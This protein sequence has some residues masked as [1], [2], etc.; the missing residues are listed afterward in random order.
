[1]INGVVKCINYG[2]HETIS[3]GALLPNHLFKRFCSASATWMA[4]H[5]WVSLLTLYFLHFFDVLLS[6]ST[7]RLAFNLTSIPAALQAS[8]LLPLDP[9]SHGI[10]ALSYPNKL[11]MRPNL[12]FHTQAMHAR[13]HT[14]P[15][16][17]VVL[18]TLV[19]Q[20][21]PPHLSHTFHSLPPDLLLSSF[22]R[23]RSGTT[24]E[25]VTQIGW[26]L[27]HSVKDPWPAPTS[28]L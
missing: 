9:P 16:L 17:R 8:S 4:L 13:S 15:V 27:W 18:Q 25:E 19:V 10:V 28:C 22:P 2:K 23:L 20:T 14:R 3:S 21:R 24:T 5:I 11:L 12:C 6:Q 26:T 7:Q 1:M